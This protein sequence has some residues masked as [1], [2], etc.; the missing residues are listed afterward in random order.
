M[1]RTEHDFF[2]KEKNSSIVLQRLYF[3][4]NIYTEKICEKK[5]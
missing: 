1:S 2:I 5:I 4:K 3:L